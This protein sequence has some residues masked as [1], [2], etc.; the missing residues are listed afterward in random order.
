MTTWATD[1]AALSPLQLRGAAVAFI[2]S[3]VR[4]H[5]IRQ[6]L[7][8]ARE[9]TSTV[10]KMELDQLT[11][12]QTIL[13]PEDQRRYCESLRAKQKTLQTEI[14]RLQDG[15]YYAKSTRQREIRLRVKDLIAE[16]FRL[17]AEVKFLQTS[18][19][20]AINQ[21]LAEQAQELQDALKHAKKAQKMT[22][23]EAHHLAKHTA[24]VAQYDADGAVNFWFAMSSASSRPSAVKAGSQAQRAGPD[25]SL[26]LAV[27]P[28]PA[29]TAT[30]GQTAAEAAAADVPFRISLSRDGS[31]P[32]SQQGLRGGPPRP[33]SSSGTASWAYSAAAGGGG[34]GGG[35]GGGAGGGG[36]SHVY[37]R[38][39][40]S[41]PSKEAEGKLRPPSPGR[42]WIG[43]SEHRKAYIHSVHSKD[44]TMRRHLAQCMLLSAGLV[45]FSSITIKS[46]REAKEEVRTLELQRAVA[47]LSIKSPKASGAG[48]PSKNPSKEAERVQALNHY[49]GMID[50]VISMIRYKIRLSYVGL[51]KRGAASQLPSFGY[52]PFQRFAVCII[53]RHW[54]GFRLRAFFDLI[55]ALQ[56]QHVAMQAALASSVI[57]RERFQRYVKHAIS[58][59]QVN[60]M[61]TQDACAILIQRQ[62]RFFWCERAEREEQ[63]RRAE[64]AAKIQSMYRARRVGARKKEQ[65]SRLEGLESAYLTALKGHKK[66]L[67]RQRKAQEQAV[68]AADGAGMLGSTSIVRGA[69]GAGAV[70]LGA[71]QRRFIAAIAEPPPP[72]PELALPGETGGLYA[73]MLGSAISTL[74]PGLSRR[75]LLELRSYAKPPGL[76]RRVLECVC[77]LLGARPDWESA[78]LQLW[79]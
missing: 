73:R 18:N 38:L 50:Y 74:P 27:R 23:V 28:F 15:H 40:V 19:A 49:I 35:G 2:Q 30:E 3:H 54:R 37:V 5:R 43:D 56:R 62:L 76:V 22:D 29:A 64:S 36:A 13:K 77:L 70:T 8:L 21:P 72:P 61:T 1:P 79:L 48:S 65:A 12:K 39:G 7:E 34:S 71:S 78:K 69:S 11:N 31:R 20:G 4:G 17:D 14:G 55:E 10:L 33:P 66:A 53:Q 60:D 52:R 45:E 16:S 68:V 75:S 57:A 67:R 41:P 59:A 47:A 44:L 42:G 25:V 26:K 63:E 58:I 9:Q 24:E 32:Q 6:Q 51:F 46:I